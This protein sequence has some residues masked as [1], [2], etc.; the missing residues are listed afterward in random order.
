MTPLDCKTVYTDFWAKAF[1][2]SQ[3]SLENN[4]PIFSSNG[5]YAQRDPERFIY[6]YYDLINGKKI[7]SSSKDNLKQLKE[8]LFKTNLENLTSK[9]V[10]TLPYFATKKLVFNDIDH[11]LVSDLNDFTQNNYDLI[12]R[13]LSK[14]DDLETF[15][16]DCSEDDIDTLDLNLKAHFG[17]GLFSDDQLVAISRY[18]VIPH[19]LN[20]A[21]ITVCVKKSHRGLG[22]SKQ[23]V[24]DLIRRILKEG[25]CPRYRVKEDNIPSIK[26][27]KRLG[28]TKTHQIM[29][30]EIVD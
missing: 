20:L 19:T 26:I 24:S 12:I 25:L 29:A 11:Y 5:Y 9:T 1:G 2:I 27:A 17:L 28:L 18:D 21:D 30:W 22:F 10:A 14:K 8:N 4:E 13:P 16:R 7:F 3:I 23:I 6:F 15:Y